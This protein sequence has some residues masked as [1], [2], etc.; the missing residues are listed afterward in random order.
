MNHLKKKII[1]IVIF[2]IFG[3][4]NS[5]FSYSQQVLNCNFNDYS[6]SGYIENIAKSWVNP[7]QNHTINGNFI[8]YKTT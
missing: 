6:N 5:W 7:S 4:L 8:N 1:L 3:V 2:G